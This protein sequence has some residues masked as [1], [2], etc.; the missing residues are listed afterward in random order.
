MIRGTTIESGAKALILKADK[1]FVMLVLSA[2][3]KFNNKIFKKVLNI[4]SL[5]FAELEEVKNLTV[6]NHHL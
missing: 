1:N 4:K 3:L 6:I 2:V 5:R